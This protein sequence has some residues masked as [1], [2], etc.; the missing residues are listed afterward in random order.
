MIVIVSNLRHGNFLEWF[1]D[2]LTYVY[3]NSILKLKD[4]ESYCHNV[5]GGEIAILSSIG[6]AGR[7]A[8]IVSDR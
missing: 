2:V 7:L 1:E 5:H 8:E 4:S 6:M 3:R